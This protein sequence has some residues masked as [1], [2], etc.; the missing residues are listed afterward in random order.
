L[1]GQDKFRCNL[2]N[3]FE[4]ELEG[5]ED[6]ESFD[7]SL[8]LWKMSEILDDLIEERR[9]GVCDYAEMLAII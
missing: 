7:Q 5:E 3:A 8:L 6:W 1:D 2:E 4:K 9:K